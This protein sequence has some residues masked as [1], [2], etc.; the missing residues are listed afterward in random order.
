MS[1]IA[2]VVIPWSWAELFLWVAV[3]YFAMVLAVGFVAFFA[4]VWRYGTK[5][6]DWVIRRK[7]NYGCCDHLRG[8]IQKDDI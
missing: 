7:R 4:Q 6:A 5:A 2:D 1:E 8:Y 3:A